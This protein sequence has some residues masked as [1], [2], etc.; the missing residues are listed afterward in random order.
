MTEPEEHKGQN[1]EDRCTLFKIIGSIL[2][3]IF[4]FFD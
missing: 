4:E 3:R 1:R 2:L